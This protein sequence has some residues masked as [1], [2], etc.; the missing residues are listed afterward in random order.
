M[1]DSR[2]KVSGGILIYRLYDTAWDI[3]PVKV[4]DRKGRL[5]PVYPKEL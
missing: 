5:S 3:N 1:G 4:E 2:L